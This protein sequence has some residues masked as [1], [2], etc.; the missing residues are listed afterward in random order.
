[1]F[2]TMEFAEE[3]EM[4]EIQYFR[5]CPTNSISWG[6]WGEVEVYV[7]ERGGSERLLLKEDFGMT[8]CPSIIYLDEPLSANLEKA[9]IK[10]L[11]AKPFSET[12]TK[13]ASAASIEFGCVNPENFD[14]LAY[15][16]DL[17]CSELREEITYEDIMEIKDP[18]ER[19][20]AIAKNIELF[21]K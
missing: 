15:F 16:T 17:S 9:T 3:Q 12:V 20:S 18:T 14:M 8:D 4:D 19:Q 2:F 21:R 11:T 6:Q 1:M 10:I 7:T 13:V 5:Y